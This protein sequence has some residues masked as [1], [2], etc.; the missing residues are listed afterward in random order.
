MPNNDFSEIPRAN[1]TYCYTNL[2]GKAWVHIGLR[3]DDL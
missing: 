3:Y 2:D 1:K